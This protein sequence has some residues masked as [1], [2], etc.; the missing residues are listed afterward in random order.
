V[1]WLNQKWDSD[2]AGLWYPTIFLGSAAI[3]ALLY[4]PETKKVSL[5]D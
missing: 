2:V 4:L 1:T 5:L 3:L